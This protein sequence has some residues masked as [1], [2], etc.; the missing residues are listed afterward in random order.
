MHKNNQLLVL[1]LSVTGTSIASGLV[2]LE[3]TH[4]IPYMLL[5]TVGL[6][7]AIF[8]IAT[9]IL[10][11]MKVGSRRLLY[12]MLAFMVFGASELVNFSYGVSA[13]NAKANSLN[14]DTSHIFNLIILG[15][16]TL[17]VVVKR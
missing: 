15:L 14:I 12:M 17:S 3:L 1:I 13:I 2:V 7:L 8:M 6:I 4:L 10:S 16:F 5:H 11:Y 9:S